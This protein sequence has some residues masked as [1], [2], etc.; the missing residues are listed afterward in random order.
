MN[1]QIMGVD[2]AT[3]ETYTFNLPEPI[4]KKI[5]NCD[6]SIPCLRIL[7]QEKIYQYNLIDPAEM[8]EPTNIE[9]LEQRPLNNDELFT[10]YSQRVIDAT[11]DMVEFLQNN[12]HLKK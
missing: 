4:A 11:R 9:N 3:D 10:F 6:N 2:I 7:Y 5:I 8:P 1:A 12:P